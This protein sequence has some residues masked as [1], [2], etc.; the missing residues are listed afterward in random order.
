MLVVAVG[1]LAVGLWAATYKSFDLDRFFVP[2]EL[3]L[4]A[5][6]LLVALPLALRRRRM[7]ISGVDVV[8]MLF[9]MLSALSALFAPNHW[10][11]ARALAVTWSSLMVFWS[12]GAVAAGVPRRERAVVGVLVV[13]VL[14]VVATALAQAYGVDSSHFSLNRAPGGTLG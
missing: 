14:A 3:A 9:L 10:L 7:E 4:H 5:T 8:L 1:A 2:K 13:A 6:A 12:V 11:S